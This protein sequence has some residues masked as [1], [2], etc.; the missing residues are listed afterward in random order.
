MS[1][2]L[3]LLY[4]FVAS[5][6][7]MPLARLDFF[8]VNPRY[9]YFKYLSIFMFLWTIIIGVRYVANNAYV[10]YYASLTVYPLVFLL[11][12]LIFLAIMRY[13]DKK[14]SKWII[15]LF[16]L[17]FVLDIGFSY[18]N[19]LHK[20]VLDIGFSESLTYEMISTANHGTVFYIHTAICYS[21]LIV[22]I[23]AIT[24]RLFNNF[25]R[26]KDIFPFITMVLAIV[27][28][29]TAN[30]IHLFVY[31]IALDPTYIALVLMITLL[32]V[33][34]YIRDLKLIFKFNGNEFIL[35]N[36]REMYLLV[37][38]QGIIISAS[39][40]LVNRFKLKIE[41]ELT[42]SDFKRLVVDK[43]VIYQD[44]KTIENYYDKNKVYLHMMEKEINLPLLKH[45]GKFYLFY[46]ETQNQKNINDINY[47]MTHDL[48]TKIYNRN[49]FESLEKD[50]EDNYHNYSL[51]MFDLDGLKLF[52]DYLGHSEGDRLLIRFAEA[53]KGIAHAYENLIPIRMGGDEFLLI[54]LNK[55]MNDIEEILYDLKKNTSHND[56][57]KHIGFSYGYAFNSFSEKKFRKVLIEADI[58]LYE[59]KTSR[60]K[61]KEELEQYLKSRQS[62]H[63]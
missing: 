7:V 41:D 16:I 8:N 37:N 55:D 47:V 20:L 2:Y 54:A 29:I 62:N 61:A 25:K 32:Y 31:S 58:N 19:T 30:V 5:L 15:Y 13:L 46:D 44:P 56:L 53:L 12:A 24:G 59:M 45:S 40:E 52:N 39:N 10:I 18:T 35:N 38:Q 9:N 14:V 17:V 33:I 43:A 11:T 50:I 42:F 51:I 60:K 49:Y 22:A 63:I 34:F 3:W 1:I 48:M 6:S 36:L 27:L 21:I 57:S 4:M 23:V 28:G 26:E